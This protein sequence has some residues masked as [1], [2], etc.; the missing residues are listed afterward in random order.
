L[1]GEVLGAVDRDGRSSTSSISKAEKSIGPKTLFV[2][3]MRLAI[4]SLTLFNLL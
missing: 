1:P 2:V 4:G 3:T